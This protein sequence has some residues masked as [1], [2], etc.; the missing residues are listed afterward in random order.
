MSAEA[1]DWSA[2]EQDFARA[3]QAAL[4]LPEAGLATQILPVLPDMTVGGSTDI[5]DISYVVPVGVF[6][7][8]TLPLGVS[9]HTWPVTACGGM[10]IGDKASLSS[11]R[12][13][14]GAGHDLMTQAPLR[15]AAKADLA[16]RRGDTVF[17][18]PL[19]PDRLIPR[20][21]P[22]YMHKSG[23]DDTLAPAAQAG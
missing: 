3:C 22:G 4:G 13:L 5:G 15:T 8:P 2:G 7:W 16:R 9:L 6:G 23:E 17:V 19:P 12:I 14:A 21:L 10:S 1:L 20:G 11:A 18:S